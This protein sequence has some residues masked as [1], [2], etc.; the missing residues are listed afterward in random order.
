[1]C[2]TYNLK[3]GHE[4]CAEIDISKLLFKYFEL[5]QFDS[6]IRRVNLQSITLKHACIREC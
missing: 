4:K 6:V 3:I 5:A 2:Y 1:M